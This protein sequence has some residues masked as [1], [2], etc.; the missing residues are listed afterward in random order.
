[1]WF[2]KVGTR[3]VGCAVLEVSEYPQWFISPLLDVSIHGSKSFPIRDDFSFSSH[4]RP[5]KARVGRSNALKITTCMTTME[6]NNE[7]L[8]NI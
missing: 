6:V 4:I 2:I 3:F 1:M 7:N 8:R 5:S